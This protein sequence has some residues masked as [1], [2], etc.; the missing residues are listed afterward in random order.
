[1]KNKWIS[2]EEL[3]DFKPSAQSFMRRAQSVSEKVML[4]FARGLGFPDDYFI[5]A[6]DVSRPDAQ[7]VLRLLHYFEV[8]KSVPVPEGYFRAGAHADWDLLV[9][10]AG[11]IWK[12]H[13]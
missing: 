8:D 12:L 1:M 6:H 5:K 4:C 3:P 10:G 7:S 13:C 11:I 2:Q 9:S